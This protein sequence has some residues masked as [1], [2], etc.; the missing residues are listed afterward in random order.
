MD[1]HTCHIGANHRLRHPP[2]Y[3]SDMIPIA[4]CIF[5]RVVYQYPSRCACSAATTHL[6]LQI[7][8]SICKLVL[9]CGYY[10][11]FKTVSAGERCKPCF[12]AMV[13]SD[14][15]PLWLVHAACR[16]PART[17]IHTTM[18]QY[19]CHG[20]HS[21]AVQTGFATTF[22]CQFALRPRWTCKQRL[23][24]RCL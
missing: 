11:V 23:A 19:F 1:G 10:I 5:C 6:A 17:A 4:T 18:K 7:C 22:S 8:P 20:R 21:T 12:S 2:Q 16:A 24:H 13:C 15:T 14:H 3:S 9:V